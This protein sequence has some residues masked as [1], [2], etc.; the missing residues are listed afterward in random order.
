MQVFEMEETFG[1]AR[2]VYPK[3]EIPVCVRLHGPWFLNGSAQGC[4]R[5]SVFHNRVY[6][7]GQAIRSAFA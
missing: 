3:S 6:D 7:E 5:D 2:R 4:P 1:L